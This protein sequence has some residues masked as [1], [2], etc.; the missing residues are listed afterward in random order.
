LKYYSKNTKYTTNPILTED[1]ILS[2]MPASTL[3]RRANGKPSKRDKAAN[4]QYLTPQ[5]ERALVAH[6]LRMA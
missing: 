2:Y 4:Q 5:E 3:W 6:V 1:I